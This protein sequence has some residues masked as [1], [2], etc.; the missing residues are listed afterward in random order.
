[1]L[2]KRLTSLEELVIRILSPNLSEGVMQGPLL[3]QE[4]IVCYCLMCN[5]RSTRF[6][7]LF[8]NISLLE[9]SAYAKV[10]NIFARA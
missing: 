3:Q 4:S 5:T 1:M 9:R 10:A 8:L 7:S 6:G 2:C